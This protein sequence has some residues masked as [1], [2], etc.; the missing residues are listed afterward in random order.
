[1]ERASLSIRVTMK[2]GYVGMR[3][4][5]T[6]AAPA[7]NHGVVGSSPSALNKLS[8]FYKGFLNSTTQTTTR[9]THLGSVR[10]VG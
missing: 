2:G 8:P 4:E 3:I 7:F 1:M 9:K 6:G 10:V 5:I